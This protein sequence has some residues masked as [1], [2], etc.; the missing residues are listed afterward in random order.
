MS[1]PTIAL[2]GGIVLIVC[3]FITHRTA[4]QS[5]ALAR[6]TGPIAGEIGVL[7]VISAVILAT[8]GW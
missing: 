4:D 5:D 8:C 3:G 6:L 2:L 7:F 1:L